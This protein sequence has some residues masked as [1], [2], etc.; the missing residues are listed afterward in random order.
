MRR[1]KLVLAAAALTVSMLTAIA[2]PALADDFTRCRDLRGDFVRCYGDL[3]QGVDNNFRINDFNDDDFFF[4]SPFFVSPF[5][6]SPFF[7]DG[8]GFVSNCPFAGDFEGP[9]NE[10]DCFD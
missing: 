1:I 6:V 9:V 4:G 5:F 8:F 7:F 2:S 10:F 3:F